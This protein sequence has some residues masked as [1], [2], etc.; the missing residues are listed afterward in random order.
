MK[1]CICHFAKSVA[2]TLSPFISKGMLY[3]IMIKSHPQGP[4]T[5]S[6][7][8][9]KMGLLR[10]VIRWSTDTIPANTTRWPNAGLMLAHRLRRWASINPA[11]GQ[12]L[13]FA[14]ITSPTVIPAW[15]LLLTSALC[16]LV[17]LW[18]FHAITTLYA[19]CTP[20]PITTSVYS[21]RAPALAGTLTSDLKPC[22]FDDFRDWEVVFVRRLL[23]IQDKM[24]RPNHQAHSFITSRITLQ[25]GQFLWNISVV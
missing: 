5:E 19:S 3:G 2:D 20:W 23:T 4:Y 8:P 17:T 13:V 10:F 25:P 7:C 9:E 15:S 12:C 22:F 14:G 1:G 6:L 16:Q 21:C 24:N 11:L 18:P